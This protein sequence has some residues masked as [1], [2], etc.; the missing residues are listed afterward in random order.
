M[1]KGP[2][3]YMKQG[4]VAPVIREQFTGKEWVYFGRRNLWP[5]EMRTLADNCAPL[6]TC[7]QTLARMIAGRGITF[8]TKAGEELPEAQRLFD[9][10]MKDTTQEDFLYA[11]AYDV[12]FL[13][14]L[15]WVPRRSASDIVRLDHL[16]VS[17]VR[18]G[19][20]NDEGRQDAF[21]WCANWAM[22]NTA[23]KERF[24]VQELPRYESGV[25]EDRAVL[26]TKE[27]SPGNDV[28][29]MPW[30]LGVIKAAEVWAS[31]DPYNKTQI[32][33][34]F[35]SRVHLHTFTNLDEESL[36]KYDKRVMNAYSGS[37]GRGIFHT[38]GTPEEGAPQITVLPR[39]DGAGELDEM[40]DKAANVIYSGYGMPKILMGAD[41]TTGMD[42]AA[43]AIRQAHQTVMQMLV[44]PKQQMITKTIVRLMNDAGIANVWEARID[45]LDLIN[46]G[47]DEVM[48]RQAYLAS[49][50]RDEHRERVL[51]MPVLGGDIGG[52]LLNDGGKKEAEPDANKPSK[53]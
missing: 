41:T 36:D 31:V 49:V 8:H 5:A 38:Y 26:Y 39:G 15:A 22:V 1:S 23:N 3:G 46:E 47:Q 25:A 45:Q 13:N 27:Y 43:N 33:T 19:H 28:Y 7:M 17:R 6:E 40:R 24:K 44:I 35:S 12:A 16:D 29:G 4:T 21:Y 37:M 2:K 14:A 9:E 30:W 53:E 52:Q 20:L 10:W 50:T 48:N 34:G 32:D 42:G 18:S 11:S 51:D